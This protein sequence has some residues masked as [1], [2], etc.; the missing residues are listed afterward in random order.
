MNKPTMRSKICSWC[1]FYTW[2]HNTE[3]EDCPFKE[4]SE[5]EFR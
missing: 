5:N 1:G 3:D 2:Q 4:E